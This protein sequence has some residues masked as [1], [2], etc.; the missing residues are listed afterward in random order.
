VL[1]LTISIQAIFYGNR[2]AC[3]S[4]MGEFELAVDDCNHALELT[5]EYVKVLIRRSQAYEK[6]EKLDEALA[7]AK[8]I[9]EIDTQYPKISSLVKRLEFSVQEK[10]NKLKDE[11]LGT[12]LLY[13][14][15]YGSFI[16]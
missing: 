10:N 5:P 2:A 4:N 1:N 9:Q 6:L 14:A 3:Y 16:F 7:D 8:K 13:P 11:A 15:S 12:V